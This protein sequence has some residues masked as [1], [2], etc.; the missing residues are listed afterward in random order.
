MHTHTCSDA[1]LVIEEHLTIV[2]V[3]EHMDPGQKSMFI[4]DNGA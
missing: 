3:T 2:T 4:L 1:Q